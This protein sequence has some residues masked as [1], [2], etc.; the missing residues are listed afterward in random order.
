METTNCRHANEMHLNR[1]EV[2]ESRDTQRSFAS[3]LF[4]FVKVLFDCR[5]ARAAELTGS[6]CGSATVLWSMRETG[7]LHDKRRGPKHVH[8]YGRCSDV[9]L[10]SK[11]RSGSK[12]SARC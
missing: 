4:G 2:L 9:R 1:P 12:N 6:S 10:V 8:G 11:M 5:A 7:G 3:I